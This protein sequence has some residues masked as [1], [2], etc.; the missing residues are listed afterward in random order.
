MLLQVPPLL[1]C[2][3]VPVPAVPE[4]DPLFAAPPPD[5]PDLPLL[6]AAV[7]LLPPP[8]PPA[9]D[10]MVEKTEFEPSPP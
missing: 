3:E 4:A 6:L 9:V 2:P 1:P 8:P 10:V 5:P 7:R